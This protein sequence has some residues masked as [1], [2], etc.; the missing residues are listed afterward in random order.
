M[1]DEAP[2]SDYACELSISNKRRYLEKISGI[3]DPYLIPN[4]ELMKNV[5]PPVMNTDISIT[6]FLGPA[7]VLHSGLRL[8]KALMPTSISFVDL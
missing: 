5:F 1:A 7:F 3:Q 4:H 2:L 8:T 6:Y